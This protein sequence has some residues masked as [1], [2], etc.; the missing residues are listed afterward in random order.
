[1]LDTVALKLVPCVALGH[2]LLGIISAV[3]TKKATYRELGA[4]YLDRQD[5]EKLTA[6]LLKRLEKL[7]VKVT[8]EAE[9]V[10]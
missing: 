9:A 1:M 5:K 7:G 6:R 8:V 2:T 4:D 10:A 3:L